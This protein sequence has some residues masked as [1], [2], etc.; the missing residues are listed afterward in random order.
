MRVSLITIVIS[1]ILGHLTWSSVYYWNFL[2]D[3]L[4]PSFSIAE[5]E[6]ARKWEIENEKF[7]VQT[8]ED[9]EKLKRE[10]VLGKSQTEVLKS[11]GLPS[12]MSTGARIPI[13]V[14]NETNP[15]T[16]EREWVKPTTLINYWHYR[17]FT[18]T[19]KDKKCVTFFRTGGIYH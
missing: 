19:F 8:A 4:F 6:R 11:W 1:F 17:T 13:S 16:F 14:P 2:A 18:I 10:P 3:L 12:A 7:A 5:R 9:T 15:K